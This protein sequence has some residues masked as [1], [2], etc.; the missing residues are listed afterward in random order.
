MRKPRSI[1]KKL[2]MYSVFKLCTW[3]FDIKHKPLIFI[4]VIV[5]GKKNNLR[6]ADTNSS[7]YYLKKKKNSTNSDSKKK[8]KKIS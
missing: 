1:R 4:G 8:R 2:N 6:E 3:N 7:K 5:Y